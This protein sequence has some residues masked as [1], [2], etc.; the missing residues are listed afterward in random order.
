MKKKKNDKS[1]V[2]EFGEMPTFK[3]EAR[4]Q[5]N[6]MKSCSFK[7]PTFLGRE[8]NSLPAFN[9]SGIFYL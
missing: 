5:A 4:F 6:P 1:W 8:P 2:F 9:R 7:V 3:I